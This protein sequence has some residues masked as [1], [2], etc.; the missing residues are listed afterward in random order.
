VFLETPVFWANCPSGKPE[1][2]M[3]FLSLSDS[4]FLV[5]YLLFVVRAYLFSHPIHRTKY[6][7]RV[8]CQNEKFK[9][10]VKE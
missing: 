10:M 3:I 9:K 7:V 5:A 1:S 4:N 2:R 8:E 6:L